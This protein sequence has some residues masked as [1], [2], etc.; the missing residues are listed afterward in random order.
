M[1]APVGNQNR[2]KH[3]RWRDALE[4]SLAR[5]A[6]AVDEENYEL[7]RGIMRGLDLVA[8]RVVQQACDGQK[9]AWLEIANRLDGRPVQALAVED[10]TDDTALPT[11]IELRVIRPQIAHAEDT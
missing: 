7:E 10:E 5:L 11:R 2:S 3:R 1:G 8:D 4:R 6:D 9:D